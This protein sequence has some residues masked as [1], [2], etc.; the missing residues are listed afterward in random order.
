MFMLNSNCDL[1]ESGIEL[2]LNSD[3]CGRI[4]FG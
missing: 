4:F 3:S 1:N 2:V